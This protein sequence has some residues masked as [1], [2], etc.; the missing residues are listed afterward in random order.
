MGFLLNLIILFMLIAF[1]F[2]KWTK[3]RPEKRKI[4]FDSLKN[5]PKNFYKNCK[6]IVKKV[7]NK[8]L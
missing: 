7:K 3:D 4:L 8:E 6:T 2:Y 1:G 5:A